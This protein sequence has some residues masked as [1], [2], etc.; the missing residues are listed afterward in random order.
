MPVMVTVAELGEANVAPLAADRVT[1]K[2]LF[3]ENGVASLMG[4]EKVFGDESP[5]AQLSVPFSA[6]YSPPATALPL[7]VAYATLAVPDEPPVR[8]TVTVSVPEL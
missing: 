5:F 4:I 3:P 7:L 2:D 8:S 6:V 1:A